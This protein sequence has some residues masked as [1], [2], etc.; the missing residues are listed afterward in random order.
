MYREIFVRICYTTLALIVALLSGGVLI[1]SSIKFITLSSPTSMGLLGKILNTEWLQGAANILPNS[2]ELTDYL[3]SPVIIIAFLLFVIGIVIGSFNMR[4]I[5]AL[6]EVAKE[7][8]RRKD[9][10]RYM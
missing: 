9:I 5:H 8:Q 1:L 6:R 10:D 7:I 4:R 3:T 2:V